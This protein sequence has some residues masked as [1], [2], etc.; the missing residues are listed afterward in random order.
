[1]LYLNH[2]PVAKM[3]VTR[4][5]KSD[6]V[7][8]KRHQQNCSNFPRNCTINRPMNFVAEFYVQIWYFRKG[9]IFVVL[10]ISTCNF[11]TFMQKYYYFCITTSEVLQEEKLISNANIARHLGLVFYYYFRR[12]LLCITYYLCSI[13][14]ESRN[15]IFY[16]LRWSI[17]SVVRT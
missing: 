6:D 10:F 7:T 15:V 14:T 2:C 11:G 13:T 17:G 4:D 12:V 5:W 1:M 8:Y 16:S 3:S 9:D